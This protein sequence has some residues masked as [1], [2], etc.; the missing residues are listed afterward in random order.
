[1]STNKFI[2]SGI[3]F[4]IALN[5]NGRPDFTNNIDLIISSIKMILFWPVNQR[6]FNER[7]GSR[8]EEL[9]EEPNDGVAKSLLKIFINEALYQYEKRVV[10]NSVKVVS[11]DLVKVNIELSISIRN[12]RIEETFIF[13]YYKTN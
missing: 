1:M 3:V 4:P 2:G 11:Y 6:S 7:F 12:T 9:I 5:A 10:V 13:P 8:I